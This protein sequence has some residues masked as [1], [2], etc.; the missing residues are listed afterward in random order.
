MVELSTAQA[1]ADNSV[2]SPSIAE[3]ILSDV[4]AGS[5][6]AQSRTHRP[7]VACSHLVVLSD[8]QMDLGSLD[9]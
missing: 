5:E 6:A 2:Q 7:A 8:P 4:S 1:E 9:P 3:S